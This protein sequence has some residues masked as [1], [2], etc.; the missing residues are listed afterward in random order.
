[1]RGESDDSEDSDLEPEVE[2]EPWFVPEDYKVCAC[3]RVGVGGCARVG[4]FY[5]CKC[6]HASV[7]V[8][9]VHTYS[10][11]VCSYTC[12]RACVCAGECVCT[13]ICTCQLHVTLWVWRLT[14]LCTFSGCISGRW[15]KGAQTSS[16][17]TSYSGTLR[18]CTGSGQKA[19]M[20][21]RAY[22]RLSLPLPIC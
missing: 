22:M 20:Y 11:C 4:S 7:R 18:S 16:R 5:A 19:G 9:H 1:M 14:P 13:R 17:A 12:V 8:R 10:M 2:L 6:E 3:V 15:W 21:V